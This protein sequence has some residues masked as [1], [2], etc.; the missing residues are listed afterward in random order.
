MAKGK[1]LSRKRLGTENMRHCLGCVGVLPHWARIGQ[2]PK[3]QA[4]MIGDTLS[5]DI[6]G[7]ADYGLD[8]CWYNPAGQPRAADLP[9]TYEIR[10]LWELVA[11]LSQLFK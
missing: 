11:L 2:P 5:A 8:T 4:L 10:R 7:A 9:L 6:R 1:G 3:S